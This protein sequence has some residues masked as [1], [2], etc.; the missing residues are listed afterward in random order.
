MVVMNP[1]GAGT[2]VSSPGPYATG[3]GKIWEAGDHKTDNKILTSKEFL[4]FFP[5]SWCRQR[6][7]RTFIVSGQLNIT[8]F[9]E[10]VVRL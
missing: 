1:A 7:P 4:F 5:S 2:A 3:Y 8:P 6:G 10:G 9:A